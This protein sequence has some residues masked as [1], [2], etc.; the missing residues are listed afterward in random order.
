[1]SISYNMLN[2]ASFVSAASVTDWSA[3][4]AVQVSLKV[5]QTSTANAGVRMNAGVGSTAAGAPIYRN[6]TVTSTVRN[7]VN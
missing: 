3:V 1:M 7:R 5:Q 4:A 6:Y 2:Q